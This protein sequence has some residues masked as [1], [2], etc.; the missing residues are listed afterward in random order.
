MLIYNENN[1]K[2]KRLPKGNSWK[3]SSDRF[4]NSFRACRSRKQKPKMCGGGK[5]HLLKM[6]QNLELYLIF[7]LKSKLDKSKISCIKDSKLNKRS[8]WDSNKFK[9]E[10]ARCGVVNKEIM[11]LQSIPYNSS[12]KENKLNNL[13]TTMRIIFNSFLR[14]V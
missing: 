9:V 8:R 1:K 4:V 5:S 12:S 6:N 11:L 7:K 3:N 2:F 14:T 13:K 10:A